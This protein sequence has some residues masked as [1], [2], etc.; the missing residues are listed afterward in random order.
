[1]LPYPSSWPRP[2]PKRPTSLA[3]RITEEQ[4][5]R[6]Y[7]REV[8]TR[9]LAAVLNVHE[10]YLSYKF[11]TKAP[12][13]DTKKLLQARKEYKLEIAKQVLS[14]RYTIGQAAKIAH[15][16]YNTMARFVA[17]AKLL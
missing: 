3:S 17:K 9:E 5:L 14:N 6:L 12:I 1:M 10:N 15:T 11:P 16:S 2:D 4:K 13:P 7:N 8:T